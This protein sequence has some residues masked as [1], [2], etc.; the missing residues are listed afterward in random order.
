MKP[1]HSPNRY[2]FHTTYLNAVSMQETIAWANACIEQRTA[3]QLIG[4]SADLYVSLQ[5]DAALR[6]MINACPMINAGDRAVVFSSR[7]L[8]VPLPACIP[9]SELVDKLLALANQSR[10]RIFIAGGEPETLQHVELYIRLFY[11]YL[12]V[13]G[14]L[15]S[16]L[17][18]HEEAEAMHRIATSG[19]DILFVALP[20]PDREIWLHHHLHELNVPLCIGADMAFAH[21]AAFIR[22]TPSWIRGTVLER[23]FSRIQRNGQ[24]IRAF[25]RYP[26]FFIS[27]ARAWRHYKN[28]QSGDR[29]GKD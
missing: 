22:Q 21:Y 8:G 29:Q 18:P 10:H 14:S 23:L 17:Y 25:K 9:Q 12:R 26:A 24:G 6:E 20:S 4:L 3:A 16:W 13:S 2:P 19:A 11:P 28:S 27:M 7:L 15:P 5:R 1:I